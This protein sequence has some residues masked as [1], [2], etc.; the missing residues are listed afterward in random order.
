MVRPLVSACTLHSLSK[1]LAPTYE[2]L[3]K[4]VA[5]NT[6]IV[7]AKVDSTQH[8]IPGVEIKGYPTV[9][10]FKKGPNPT[11]VDYRQARTLDAFV[12]F[13]KENTRFVQNKYFDSHEWVELEPQKSE[14]L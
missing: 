4:K 8:K 14:D 3:A 9:K 1:K 6:N 2:E 12:Q 10:L 5:P 7:I 11:V 13:L